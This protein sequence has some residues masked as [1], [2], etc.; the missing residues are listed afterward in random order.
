MEI[1]LFSFGCLQEN[2]RPPVYYPED[3][4]IS[5]KKY[6]KCG[7]NNANTKSIYDAVEDNK[8]EKNL[9]LNKS[10]TLPPPSKHSEYK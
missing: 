6:S 8:P 7:S 3:Y 5:L 10:Q 9:D 2:Q 4:V 1:I